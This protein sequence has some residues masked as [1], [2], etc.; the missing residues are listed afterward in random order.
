MKGLIEHIPGPDVVLK[1][2][3]AGGKKDLTVYI[4]EYALT[5]KKCAL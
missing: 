2:L 1:G 5:Q 3:L 4:R